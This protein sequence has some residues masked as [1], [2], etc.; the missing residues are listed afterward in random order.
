MRLCNITE[1]IDIKDK[2]GSGEMNYNYTVKAQLARE[3][4][5]EE[6]IAMHAAIR[7]NTRP[8]VISLTCLSISLISL[9]VVIRAARHPK[10]PFRHFGTTY[11]YQIVL[12]LQLGRKGLMQKRR[13]RVASESKGQIAIFSSSTRSEPQ[14]LDRMNLGSQRIKWSQ[15]LPTYIISSQ[16]IITSIYD[17]NVYIS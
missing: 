15:V 10:H 8:S 17:R 14:S 2:D 12:C 5:R 7:S 13:R 3:L 6:F 16:E 11:R 4:Q 1:R 9:T